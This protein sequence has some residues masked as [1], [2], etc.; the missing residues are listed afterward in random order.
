MS[1]ALSQFD[2]ADIATPYVADT[3]V[4]KQQSNV[5]DQFDAAAKNADSKLPAKPS[6]FPALSPLGS[7]SQNF[8]AGAGKAVADLG[9]GAKQLIDIPAQYLES[10]FPGLSSWAQA[11]GMPSAAASSTETNADVAESQKLDAPLMA[12][13]A[14]IGGNI[15]G[16][17]AATL[18]PL[19]IAAKAS[20]YIRGGD[21]AAALMNPANYKSAISAGA[22]NGALQ[23]TVGDQSKIANVGIGAVAGAGG[24]LV[25][26]TIGRIAQ[27]VTNILSSA[28]DKAVATLQAAGIPLDAA[29]QSGSAFLNKLRSSFSDNP[30]T[31]SAQKE[32]AASQQSGYNRAVLSSI[33]ENASAATPEVMNQAATRINGVFKDVLGRNNVAITDPALAKFASIQAAAT[34]EEKK[35]VA[36]IADRLMN[37][38]QQDGT[39]PG[40]TAYNIK[41]DLERLAGSQDTTLGYH[42][43]QLRSALMDTINDSLSP[44]DQSA[45]SQARG[46]FR[47][48]KRL[49]PAIDRMGNGDISAA[50]LA[51]VMAQKGNRGA[52]LYGRGDQTLVDL[53]HAGNMLLP[54]K[55]PNSGS[56]PRGIMQM[57]IPLAAG[58][59][60]GAYTGDWEKAGMTAAGMYAIPKAAQYMVNNPAT[61]QYL[62]QGMQGS[63]TPIRNL[64]QLPKTTDLIGGSVRR[65]PGS[66]QTAK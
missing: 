54:D 56:I 19:G 44:A 31:G 49:E 50:K 55:L 65:L 11:H 63:M 12:T 1:D 4:V 7:D 5:L 33:G 46:Q 2:A 57:A 26:N 61:S 3:P 48:L 39:V 42:A 35:P 25:T 17:I 52:S 18:A 36:A 10:K 32:L 29:Q 28:H 66:F 62:S 30:F 41:K 58:G 64:L 43:K 13:K 21:A 37:A 22:I 51:N 14:G 47:D 34:E 24:N 20:N 6:K 53:A 60:Q 23:P 9:R 45:F 16:N 59:A 27:P 8:A 38:V 40:Q 15:A